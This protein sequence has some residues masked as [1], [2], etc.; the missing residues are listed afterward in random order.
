MTQDTGHRT[1]G[2]GEPQTSPASVRTQE[3]MPPAATCFIRSSGT[4]GVGSTTSLESQTWPCQ[5][6]ES[7]Q[8]N[9][10]LG[11]ACPRSLSLTSAC[12]LT[13][14]YDILEHVL[15]PR[16][17]AR[18]PFSTYAL[19]E[20]IGIERHSSIPSP[21]CPLHMA[22]A[23]LVAAPGVHHAC[24][25][26]GQAVPATSGDLG[27]LNAPQRRYAPGLLLIIPAATAALELVLMSFRQTAQ[28]AHICVCT[29]S[30]AGQ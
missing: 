2:R 28:C 3:C 23:V 15:S 8:R 22:L 13:Q 7:S 9:Q 19:Y 14:Q 18:C 24:R 16:V 30:S 12:F 10:V 4:Q 5:D 1:Q 21:D 20:R 29:A 11:C 26:Q 27:D 25:V 6:S 17:C